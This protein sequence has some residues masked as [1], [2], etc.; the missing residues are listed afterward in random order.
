M[1]CLPAGG[2]G[3]HHQFVPLPRVAAVLP[4]TT[5]FRPGDKPAYVVLARGAIDLT[6]HAEQHKISGALDLFK[7]VEVGDFTDRDT[8]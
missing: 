7:L 5:G 3:L 1:L 6:L 8:Q 2:N 4:A